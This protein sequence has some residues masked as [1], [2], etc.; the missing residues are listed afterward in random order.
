MQIRL[1]TINDINQLV[2]LDR[3]S[4]LTYWS[5][6]EYIS[7][8]NQQQ[9]YILVDKS[10]VV[11]VVVIRKVFDEAEI[12][13]FFVKHS[14]KKMGYGKILLDLI[15]SRFKTKHNITRFFLEVRSDNYPAI[16]LYEKVGFQKVGVRKNY[17]RVAGMGTSDALTMLYTHC[18]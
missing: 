1:A 15:I 6:D 16:K 14:Q 5:K 12:L 7:S 3:E 2:L 8:L 17:Y 18:L 13:Q 9:I 11:A 4:N 10:L